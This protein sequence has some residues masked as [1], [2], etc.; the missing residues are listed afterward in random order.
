MKQLPSRSAKPPRR[1]ATRANRATARCGRHAGKSVRARTG[2]NG[3]GA[4]PPANTSLIARIEIRRTAARREKMASAEIRLDLGGRGGGA[5][6][7]P[8]RTS[9]RTPAKEIA[10]AARWLAA[11]GH[12]VRLKLLIHLLGG[13]AVY[14]DLCRV[15]GTASGPLY[16]H[17]NRL[18]LLDLVRAVERDLYELTV[19]GRNLIAAV[20]AATRLARASAARFQR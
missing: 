5:R 2:S 6:L 11:V 13:P 1:A 7:T 10:D 16:F 9:A 18:R 3:R 15:S 20:L 19:T 14:R 12:P 8:P 17:L 4:P